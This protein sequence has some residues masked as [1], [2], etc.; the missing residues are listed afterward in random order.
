MLGM[1]VA[2]II[3]LPPGRRNAPRACVT[4]G[5]GEIREPVRGHPGGTPFICGPMAIIPPLLFFSPGPLKSV[6]VPIEPMSVAWV[7]QPIVD[8]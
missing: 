5:H 8:S 6:Y 4:I 3:T 1:S 7:D 2:G